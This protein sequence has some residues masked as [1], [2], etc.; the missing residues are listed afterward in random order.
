MKQPIWVRE[1][2]PPAPPPISFR[3]VLTTRRQKG[4]RE[5]S[6]PNPTGG[7]LRLLRQIRSERDPALIEVML[8]RYRLL[9]LVFSVWILKR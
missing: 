9:I 7:A 2:K 5:K 3:P 8:I 1:R 6:D 4:H